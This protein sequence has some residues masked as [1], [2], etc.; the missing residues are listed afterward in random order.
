MKNRLIGLLTA[1]LLAGC[2]TNPTLPLTPRDAITNFAVDGRFALKIIH[3]DGQQEN[4]GGRISWTHE[5][6]MDR[7]LLANPLGIGLAEIESTPEKTQLRTGDGKIFE[8]ENPDQ[9]IAEVTGQP[10]PMSHLPA[11]L[12]GRPNGNGQIEND[13]MGRPIRLQEGEWRI[14]YAYENDTPD[15]PPMRLNAFGKTMEL[16]LRIE[17]WKTNP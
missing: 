3:A 13:P 14:E 1:S 4:S 10:L 6:Q 17:N 5:N 2:A 15:A 12:L 8:A 11:W 7:V 16:R 9:L